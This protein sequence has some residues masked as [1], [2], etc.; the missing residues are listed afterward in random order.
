MRDTGFNPR[1]REGATTDQNAT[2]FAG[3]GF[4]PRPREGATLASV[5]LSQ[6][7]L[8]SIHAPVRGRQY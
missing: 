4:N 2:A 3:S 1:P 8:V 5:T 6:W 7:A